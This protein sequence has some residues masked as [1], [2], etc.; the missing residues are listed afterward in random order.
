VQFAGLFWFLLMFV[1][2]VILQRLL[3]HEIQAIFLILTR[4][5]QLTVTLFSILFMPG[6]FLHESSHF[7]MAKL[8]GV[9][10]RRFSLIP[11]LLPNGRLQMG[12]V[13]VEKADMLRDSLIGLAPLLVGTLFIAYV[14]L[15][16][17]KI[18][19][20]LDT[21]TNGQLDILLTELGR[22]PQASGFY[23]WLYL[24]FAVSSM[25][26]PS[27]ADRHSWLP[28][29]MW[30]VVLFAL[31]LLGGAGPWMLG[32]LAPYLNNLLGTAA[33][34]F[35]LSLMLHIALLIPA[36]L[37]HRVISQVTRLDVG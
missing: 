28:L 20:T 2:L 36:F 37:I 6:V 26:M 25:M 27:E 23:F 11:R 29:G 8:L 30:V 24:V 7:L 9:G 12:Y 21:L 34:L 18:N 19:A 13:E 5:L 33:T 17:L 15:S 10:T 4:N 35:G 14:G 32:N 16:Q 31:A 3:H 22:L 1:P